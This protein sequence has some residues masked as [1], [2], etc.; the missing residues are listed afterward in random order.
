[1]ES[2]PDAFAR[3]LAVDDVHERHS[4]LVLLWI[5]RIHEVVFNVDVTGVFDNGR[6]DEVGFVVVGFVV[7]NVVPEAL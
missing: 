5:G 7:M 6:V 2:N 3:R 4:V 1:M